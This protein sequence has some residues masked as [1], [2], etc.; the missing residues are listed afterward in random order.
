MTPGPGLLVA[1]GTAAAVLVVGLVF[2]FDV[3]Q[4]VPPE[5]PTA[6]QQSEQAD[7]SLEARRQARLTQSQAM[8]GGGRPALPEPD[9]ANPTA[10]GTVVPPAEAPG[11]PPAP[12][13]AAVPSAAIPPTTAPVP[14]GPARKA[15]RVPGRHARVRQAATEPTPPPTP[16]VDAGAIAAPARPCTIATSGTSPVVEACRLG[17]LP[18]AKK[19]MKRLLQQ[20]KAHDARFTCETCHVDLDTFALR[21]NARADFASLLAATE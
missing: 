20:A 9:P 3:A 4:P 21:E 16:S 18:E 2:V 8:L 6:A 12:V 14:A 5:K 19:T 1:G 15:A 7:L 17:G 11:S 10:D 13:G